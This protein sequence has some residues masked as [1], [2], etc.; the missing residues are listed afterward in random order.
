MFGVKIDKISGKPHLFPK[1]KEPAVVK[2]VVTEYQLS[3]NGTDVPIGEWVPSRPEVPPGTFLWSKITFTKTDDK[4]ESV[5]NVSYVGRDGEHGGKGEPGRDGKDGQ[6]G[7]PF[8]Y[9]DFTEEQLEALKGEKGEKGDTDLNIQIW[10]EGENWA[11]HK[12]NL[13][14]IAN[15]TIN[16]GP[17]FVN[18]M[19]EGQHILIL[20]SGLSGGQGLSFDHTGGRVFSPKKTYASME[21]DTLREISIIRYDLYIICLVSEVMINDF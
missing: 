10:N 17:D 18:K 14:I 12:G 5:F 21:I 16:I 15:R 7:D 9:S 19:R 4:T 13:Y 6:K 2:S 3:D 1:K 20:Q 11:N 8:R